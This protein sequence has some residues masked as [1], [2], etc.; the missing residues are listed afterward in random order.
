MGPVEYFHYITLKFEVLAWNLK[1][2]LRSRT[3]WYASYK[4]LHEFPAEIQIQLIHF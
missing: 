3:Y 1:N 4:S 2:M